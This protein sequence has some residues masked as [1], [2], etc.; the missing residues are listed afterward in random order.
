M[1]ARYGKSLEMLEETIPDERIVALLRFELEALEMLPP[2]QPPVLGALR[3]RRDPLVRIASALREKLNEL[4]TSLD[5]QHV[6]SDREPEDERW[7]E[8]FALRGQL[9]E[10]DQLVRR[11]EDELYLDMFT[12]TAEHPQAASDCEAGARTLA[13]LRGVGSRKREAKRP[14]VVSRPMTQSRRLAGRQSG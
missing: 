3:D 11:L 9:R 10:V 14:P 5:D 13:S 1:L 4:E 12:E 7:R 8:V 6:L 2:Q